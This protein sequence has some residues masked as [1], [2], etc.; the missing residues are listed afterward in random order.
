MFE[1]FHAGLAEVATADS[2]DVV[3]VYILGQVQRMRNLRDVH[4]CCPMVEISLSII[5]LAPTS[6]MQYQA[7]A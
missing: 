6:K 5:L 3:V 2:P 1:A 4:L 7:V